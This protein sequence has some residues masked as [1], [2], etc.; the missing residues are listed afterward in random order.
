MRAGN[1]LMEQ[2]LALESARQEAELGIQART[3]FLTVTKHEMM[4][5]MHAV[6]IL[7]SLLLETELTPEQRFLMEAIQKNCNLLSVLVDDVL[8]LSRL[9]DGSLEL[10][11]N[12]FS[13]HDLF[14]EVIPK[15]QSLHVLI[16]YRLKDSL[17]IH[18]SFFVSL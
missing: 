1:Q 3:Y 14:V 5:P 10:D 15:A 18:Y 17:K 8:D 2:N 9:N 11:T 6:I 7:S 13:V 16:F 12:I 4:T